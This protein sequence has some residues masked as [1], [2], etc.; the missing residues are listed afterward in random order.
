MDPAT[1]S[2][3]LAGGSFLSKIFGS[4]DSHQDRINQALQAQKRARVKRLKTGGEMIGQ[5][6]ATQVAQVTQGAAERAA[7]L[8]RSDSTESF[9]QPIVS[10]VSGEG[11]RRLKEFISE[12]N[13][14]YDDAEA[15]LYEAGIGAPSQPNIGDF[16]AEGLGLASEYFQNKDYLETIAQGMEL[17]KTNATSLDA[18]ATPTFGQPFLGENESNALTMGKGFRPWKKPRGLDAYNYSY[19]GR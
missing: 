19:A 5:N 17:P 6:T 1:I 2:L 15:R 11:S 8:G 16:A 4:G 12:T 18:F 7:A 9:V 10:K 3:L 13:N 14:Y